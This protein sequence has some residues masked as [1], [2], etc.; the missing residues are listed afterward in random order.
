MLASVVR[1]IS[2]MRTSALQIAPFGGHFTRIF[3]TA[4]DLKV[5]TRRNT[6]K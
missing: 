4:L 2:L 3:M 1:I 5:E 6:R